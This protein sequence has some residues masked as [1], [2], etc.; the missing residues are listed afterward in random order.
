MLKNILLTGSRG[1]I[2]THLKNELLK[3]SN[4][5]IFEYIRGGTWSMV[6]NSIEEIDFIY[7]LAGEVDPKSNHDSFVSN[8]INLTEKFIQLLEQ[9]KLSI[10]ILFTSSIHAKNPKNDYGTTKQKSEEL[11]LE[12][13]Y[14]NKVQTYIYRLPHLFG[15]NCKPNYNSVISTWIYNSINDLEIKVFDRNITMHYS[16]V[17]DI[18]KEFTQCLDSKNIKQQGYL[19]PS[20][21][22]ETS[23]GEVVD[24]LEEFKYNIKN[25]KYEVIDNEFKAK[26]FTT[27][28]DYYHT[29]HLKD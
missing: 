11:I 3:N 26:L 20:I 15:Q 4:T 14:R 13:G 21:I 8:N 22:Y 10:P 16:Y 29:T 6:E 17:K 18:V 24:F 7:H 28:Q 25:S 9:K 27:Y 12:Y 5:H 1:F 23:L 19:E 2:G